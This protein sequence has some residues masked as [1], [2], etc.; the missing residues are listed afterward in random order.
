MSETGAAKASDDLPQT[1]RRSDWIG[2]FAVCF[3]LLWIPIYSIASI[4]GGVFSPLPLFYSALVF[5]IPAALVATAL[6]GVERKRRAAGLGALMAFFLDLQMPGIGSLALVG[7]VVALVLIV[8][9]LTKQWAF[10]HVRGH[11]PKVVIDGLLEWA[12]Q[13][14]AFTTLNTPAQ[15]HELRLMLVDRCSLEC[16]GQ[17]HHHQRE[18]RHA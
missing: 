13:A 11:P 17:P 3:L 9:Q 1:S 2:R 8:D 7:V 15:P 5:A 18:Q 14:M 10:D 16:T 6:G 4:H 12:R